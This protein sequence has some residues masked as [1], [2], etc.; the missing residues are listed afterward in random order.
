[1][2]KKIFFFLMII[3][4]AGCASVKP[5]VDNFSVNPK[6]I[7]ESG[8]VTVQWNVS[9]A[10]FVSITGVGENLPNVGTKDVNIDKTTKFVLTAK[11]GKETVTLEESVEVIPKKVEQQK[12]TPIV[13]ERSTIITPYVSGVINAENIKDE[14]NPQLFIN[15]VDIQKFPNEV[16]LYCTV[17]DKYG[18]HIAN[19]APPYNMNLVHKWKRIAEIIEGKETTIKNFTVE[20]VREDIAP[21]FSST[22]VLDYSGS[23][24]NDFQ[25]VDQAVMK[26]VNYIRPSK[27]DY[28]IIQFDHRIFLS[29]ERTNVPSDVNKMIPFDQLNGNTAFYDASKF[30]LNE[31]DNSS[32]EKVAILFTDGGDNS[33]IFNTAYDV[34]NYSRK[35]GAKVFVIGFNR[36]FGGFLE[37]LLTAIAEQ[38]GGKAYFPNSL[39]ELDDIFSEIYRIMK[40]YYVLTYSTEQSTISNRI[41]KVEFEFPYIDKL[42]T[43]TKKYYSKPEQIHEERVIDIVYFE[44]NKDQIRSDYL[45]IINDV[46]DNLKNNPD[47]KIEIIGHTDTRGSDQLNNALSLRRAK[48]LYSLLIK[49]GVN[50]NQITKVI[51]MGEKEPIYPNEQ[52]DLQRQ[53]NRR[54][55][56]KFI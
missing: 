50:K 43:A 8:T 41:A 55:S 18:N 31:L 47:K 22:F 51:G 56:I 35:I 4:L 29:V 37:P 27:D 2:F 5:K 19:L 21:P 48:A 45:E 15:L 42:L 46:V 13:E 33:S 30:G 20:E 26:A 38:S 3:L 34:V 40:I 10:K 14:D 53:A 9:D 52:D 24:S 32:K 49:K 28:E 36:Q 25:F 12:T 54:V 11:N 39:N 6:V 16:K 44:T 7:E 1:M 23:M 17:K